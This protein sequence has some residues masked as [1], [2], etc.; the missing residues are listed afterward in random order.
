MQAGLSKTPSPHEFGLPEKFHTWR[1]HQD[2]GFWSILDQKSRFR[3]MSCPTGSGK[4][5]LYI[6]AAVATGKRT[7]VL[8]AT[9]SLQDQLSD[10]FASIGLFD[11]RGQQ[12]YTCL[13][14]KEGGEFESM[15]VSRWG[16]PK[17]DVGPCHAGVICD[18]KN[19]GCTYFDTFKRARAA[20]LIVTNY[21]YWIAIN[22][23]GEGLGKF[24]LLVLDE[25]HAAPSEVTKA[26]TVEITQREMSE[27]G[28]SP[29]D[30]NAELSDWRRWA[31][32]QY[33]KT[34]ARLE[35]FGT[36]GRNATR[37]ERV[38][39]VRTNEIPDASELKMWKRL[40]NKCGIFSDCDEDWAV[41]VLERNGHIRACPVW[42]HDYAGDDL[43]RD[44]PQ[45]V[46]VSATVRPKTA[47]LL[48]IEYGEY[49]FED[50][51]STFP[52]E[53]RPLFWIP[54]VRV[55][56]K[57]ST[58]DKQTWAVR[59]DQIIGRRLD[60]KGIVHTVSYARAQYLMENSRYSNL[61]IANTT[62]T[63]RDTV[64]AFKSA[65]A[66]AILVSPS[67]A[68]G[69]DFIDDYARYQII[70]KIPFPDSSGIVMKLQQ[71]SDPD[72]FAYIAAQ[73]LAQM[74]GRIV[75]SEEDF[76]ESWI[77]DDNIEWFIAKYREFIPEWF[78]ETFQR[79][80]R[81]CG[82]ADLGPTW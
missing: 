45:V 43:F 56:H 50:Y 61:M 82:P 54:T 16:E 24:D 21:A 39:L 53:N 7:V 37:G 60:R 74:Y 44:V 34:Q 68:T 40:D 41:E 23:Y 59:I 58:T 62:G 10:E 70:S 4:S 38:E 33:S 47:Q 11:M 6:A 35:F 18:L 75:R 32:H 15:W 79:I 14:L 25:A 66:P 1:R 17:C 3:I 51:L 78:M 63:A 19:E 69:W 27:L 48:G 8:T 49:E 57:M 55:S 28:V 64:A 72:Y 67:V 30:A 36:L 26:L 81:V 76:G 80:D 22:K 20:H 31:R 5:P 29:L 46:M 52:R 71:E 73:D 65:P 2:D 13:A 12:N 77:V 9:K 42:V